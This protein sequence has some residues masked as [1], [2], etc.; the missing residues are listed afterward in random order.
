VR[1]D[2]LVSIVLLLQTH[3]RLT[4]AELA[5]EL[6]V[7]ERTVRR[8]LD[9]LS[10][11][12]VPVYAERGRRGGWSLLDGWRTDLSGL[13]ADE[14]RALFLAAGP[15]GL[16]EL[17]VEPAARSALRKLLATLPEDAR[18]DAEQAQRSVVV[19]AAS[20]GAGPPETLAHLGTV[21]RAVQARRRLRI[22]YATP[23]KPPGERTVDPYGLVR[24]GGVWY[25]LAGWRGE[26]R[27]FRVGRILAAESTGE[28]AP[29]PEGFDLEEAWAR[30]RQ[31]VEERRARDCVVRLRVEARLVR[32]LRGLL[33]DRAELT[34]DPAADGA[35]GLVGFTARFPD[36]RIAAADL[37]G[38]GAAVEVTEPVEVRRRLAALGSALTGLYAE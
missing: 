6:E 29:L 3:R 14:V 28:P 25:L 24:K 9:A 31:R 35:D 30:A 38:F 7:C 13:R 34:A 23:G 5:R 22:R 17:G 20:W 18:R 12:G 36:A 11:A 33:R 19:D 37:A 4:A 26:T 15:A 32:I 16:A 1:A 2:R 10:A 21:Q 27:T 8:D